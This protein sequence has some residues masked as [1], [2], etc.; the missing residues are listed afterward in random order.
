MIRAA[1]AL[2]L[3]APVP[4]LAQPA[5]AP[6]TLDEVLRSS[7]RAAPQIIEALAKIRS[8]EGRA[9]TAEG[10]FDTVFE[11]EGKS[12]ALGYYDGTVVSGRATR[13]MGDNGGYLYGNYRVTRGDFPVYEDE[14]YTNRLGEVKVG[15][16]YSLMR[17]RLVDERRT[18]RTLAAGTS[19]SPGSNA[20]RRRSG[21]SVARSTRTRTGSPPGSGCAPIATCST[22]PNGA[23]AASRGRSN[24]AR[25]PTSC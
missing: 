17:D 9:L 21:C 12:R 24:W 23:A 16:L 14:F 5:A 8:A 7:A 11:A 10:A 15:A 1:L 2:A 13:P 20:R 19:T 3:L 4:A 25:G 18:R 6:L 22:C